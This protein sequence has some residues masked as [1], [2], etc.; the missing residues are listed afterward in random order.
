MSRNFHRV[1]KFGGVLVL[2]SPFYEI[3]GPNLCDLLKLLIP[4]AE[5]IYLLRGELK[6]PLHETCS[7]I[8]HVILNS[9]LVKRIRKK[10]GILARAISYGIAQVVVAKILLELRKQIDVILIYQSE[11]AISAFV[12]RFMRKKVLVYVGGSGF[13]SFQAGKLPD[14]LLS[15]PLLIAEAIMMMLAHKIIMISRRVFVPLSLSKKILVAPTRLLDEEFFQRYRKRKNEKEL[16]I[17]YVGRLSHEKGVEELVNALP[18]I[19]AKLPTVKLLIVGDGPLRQK[20]EAKLSENNIR[21]SVLITG[22][23]NDVEAYLNEMSLLILP[24]KTEG[25]PNILFEA[26]ACETPVLVSAVG[27][28]PDIIKEGKTGFLLKSLKAKHIAERIIDLLNHPESLKSVSV[29]ALAYLKENYD[30]KNAH[31]AWLRV[32]ESLH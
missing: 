2:I 15:L 32:F 9:N 7:N 29:E 16:V 18:L 13:K 19:I 11:A 14:K 8:K 20:I 26:I 23:I 27:G 22:W 10:N 4:F 6:I 28:V 25:Q 5:T 24:S 30:A 1:R 21:D 12:A 17:G 31:D 3:A